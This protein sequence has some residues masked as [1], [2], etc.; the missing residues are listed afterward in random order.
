V[1]QSDDE[2]KRELEA[3]VWKASK[4][5]SLP[6]EQSRTHINGPLYGLTEEVF[7]LQHYAHMWQYENCMRLEY[8]S[9]RYAKYAFRNDRTFLVT[10][11]IF[12]DEQN[13][14]FGSFAS[15]LEAGCVILVNC[16]VNDRASFVALFADKEK[17]L[18]MVAKDA[19][20]TI[21]GKSFK[22]SVTHYTAPVRYSSF[23]FYYG[24]VGI[25]GE[26]LGPSIEELIQIV[27]SLHD[28]KGK[29]VD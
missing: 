13:V 7:G 8:L 5:R 26:A 25:Q 1:H 11:R 19:M 12:A 16:P 3:L 15:V 20:V 14:A 10:T 22:G 4:L 18:R 2:I 28:L 6:L 24:C 29:T 23:E 27:E 17:S 21:D 9:P